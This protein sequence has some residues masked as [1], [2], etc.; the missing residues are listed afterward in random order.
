MCVAWSEEQ[1]LWLAAFAE[2]DVPCVDDEDDDK[3]IELFTT[4]AAR[5]ID[6]STINF[7]EFKGKVVL[8]VNVASS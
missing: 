2:A 4:L 7:A 5:D 3:K 1:D 8:A 6:G